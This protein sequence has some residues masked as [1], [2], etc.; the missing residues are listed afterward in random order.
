LR[1]AGASLVREAVPDLVEEAARR[2]FTTM[3]GW[4]RY[5]G[6]IVDL[7]QFRRLVLALGT[8]EAVRLFLDHEYVAARVQRLASGQRLAVLLRYAARLSLADVAGVL[9]MTS[10]EASQATISGLEALRDLL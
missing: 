3:N 2:T 5:R 6:L 7:A 10:E 4:R 1:L 9:R 8:T